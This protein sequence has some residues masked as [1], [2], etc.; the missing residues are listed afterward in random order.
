MASEPVDVETF[1]RAE[2]SARFLSGI[3]ESATARSIVAIDGAG[4]IAFWNEGARRFYGYQRAEILGQSWTVL[5]A[6]EDVR[7]GLPEMIM[8]VALADGRWEGTVRRV[9]RDGSNFTAR[10]VVTP[11]CDGEGDLEGFVSISSDVTDEARLAREL[12]D[13]QK[14]TNSLL[15][16]APDAMVIIDDRGEIRLANAEAERQF[17]YSREELIGQPI[18]MLMPERYRQR[19]PAHR[20]AFFDAPRSRAMGVGLDLWGRR[21]DGAEFPVEI[22]LSPLESEGSA[23]ATAAIRDVTEH[24]RV[25]RQLREANSK[26]EDASRAKDRF[27]A[28]MSHELRT[29][30]NAILGFTGTILMKLPGDLNAEQERQLRVVQANGRHLL[31]LINDLLDLARIES[32]KLSLKL[33]RIDCSALLEQ[34]VTGLRPLA[35]AKQIEFGVRDGDGGVAVKSDRRALRQILINLANN[36]IKFTDEGHVQ[37]AVRRDEGRGTTLFTVTDSGCGIRAEDQAR[38]FAAFEQI[39]EPTAGPHEGTGLGLYICNSLAAALD[40]SISF[41]SEPGAGS[42]FSLELRD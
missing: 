28:S 7:D 5:Y 19:H 30:L 32:G 23:L 18:E 25:E 33:E 20:G 17:G 16:S 14:F 40:A 41:V 22:S 36:A 27:L 39:N 6:G 35:D 38:L 34:V 37:L 31:S 29:P 4:R 2:Q 9:R 1:E 42:T 21:K 10:V 24:R 13:A 15:E 11:R 26:L 12:G 3:L 8:A